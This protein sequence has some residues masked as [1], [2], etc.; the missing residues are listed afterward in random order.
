MCGGGEGA[1]WVKEGWVPCVEIV[2]LSAGL[3]LLQLKPVLNK[4]ASGG[5]C[6]APKLEVEDGD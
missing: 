2:S 3:N 4:P 1:G 6:A 5:T